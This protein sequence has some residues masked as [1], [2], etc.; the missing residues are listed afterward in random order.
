MV[1]ELLIYI[2]SVAIAIWGI[3]HIVP[4]KEVVKGF[5]SLS[6]DNKRVL[7]M[8]WIAEGFTMIFIGTLVL[9]LIASGLAQSP[10][11]I[12]VFQV[13]GLMLVIMAV[14]TSLTGSRTA[15]IFFKLCPIVK[16]TVAVLF[17]V[18]TLL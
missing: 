9:F 13:C 6:Q 10:V 2:G 18:G 7:T 4:T 8:V 11:S 3:A 1:N 17:L 12:L 16:V 14:L 15:V 5:G